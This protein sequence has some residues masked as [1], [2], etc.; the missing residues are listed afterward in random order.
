MKVRC[1]YLRGRE[2]VIKN[3]KSINFSLDVWLGDKPL[4]VQYLVLYE[5]C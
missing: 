5:V 2:Y 4:C 3:G 1:I